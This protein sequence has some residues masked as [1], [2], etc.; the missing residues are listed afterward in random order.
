MTSRVA[1]ERYESTST[2]VPDVPNEAAAVSDDFART[3]SSERR[4]LNE[5]TTGL[6]GE[7]GGGDDGGDRTG[8]SESTTAKRRSRSSVALARKTG[9]RDWMC[10]VVN[11]WFCWPGSASG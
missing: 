4:I 1:R 11:A 10:G 6:C 7:S 9:M 8:A 5:S 2:T 3:G